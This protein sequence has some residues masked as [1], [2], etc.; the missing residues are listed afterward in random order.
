MI[1]SQTYKPAF[2]QNTNSDMFIQNSIGF[3][4]IQKTIESS[5]LSMRSIKSKLTYLKMLFPDLKPE[6]IIY[7]DQFVK[8]LDSKKIIMREALNYFP[9]TETGRI[10]SKFLKHYF[11]LEPGKHRIYTF[12][13]TCALCNL[14][15]IKGEKIRQDAINTMKS[16]LSE[17][18][19]E[20]KFPQF[21]TPQ[22]DPKTL[23]YEEF[24]KIYPDQKMKKIRKE[25]EIRKILDRKE[26]YLSN[27][28]DKFPDNI[29]KTVVA[30]VLGFKNQPLKNLSEKEYLKYKYNGLSRLIISM[31]KNI[32]PDKV[33]INDIKQFVKREFGT[34]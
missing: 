12:I 14:P 4:G 10:Q 30:N 32:Q 17:K 11:S 20:N 29:E 16:I 28:L 1:I 6:N 3:C 24:I 8:Y 27:L 26:L 25:A 15:S 22:Y 9:Q 31:N 21:I 23:T 7:K 13:E 34:N 2:K 5:H 18:Q 33:D 19:F